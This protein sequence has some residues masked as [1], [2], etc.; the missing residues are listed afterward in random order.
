M[1]SSDMINYFSLQILFFQRQ[2]NVTIPQFI[3]SQMYTP[4]INIRN[5]RSHGTIV[6]HLI[7]G[8]AV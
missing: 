8:K 5:I 6:N 1:E 4:S 7:L 2:F 3:V